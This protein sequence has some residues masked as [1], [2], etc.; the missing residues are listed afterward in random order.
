VPRKR[1]RPATREA[2]RE[3]YDRIAAEFAGT[4]EHPWP[5][6]RR[7]VESAPR[8]RVGLD[9]GCGNARH[10]ELLA[11]R[12]DRTVG[13]DLSRAVLG[14][15]R[16]RATDRGFDVA[17]VQADA[18]TVPLADGTVDVAV[19]VATLHHLP[20]R[21]DRIDSLNE[22]A[23]VLA[24]A[25]GDTPG[26]ET[27]EGRALVSAW[28]VE[29]PTFDRSSAFD[30]TVDWT[31]S[32]GDHVPRYYHVYDRSSFAADLEASALAVVDRFVSDGNCYAVVGPREA[33]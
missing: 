3:T 19:Y 1:D 25:G 6:V 7:F 10:A 8:G 31:L 4:R 5:E 13:V 22:L 16:S 33:P 24:P 2:V 26:E 23:R 14:T 12:V 21:A 17:L 28:C 11:G 30:A 9:L 29:H 18:G 27:G 32:D 15:A 20:A